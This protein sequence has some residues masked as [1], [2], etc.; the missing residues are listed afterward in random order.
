MHCSLPCPCS[1]TRVKR[2][3]ELQAVL[4]QIGVM[5]PPRTHLLQ[6]RLQIIL[7]L[8][9]FFCR[10]VCKSL[11]FHAFTCTR[12]TTSVRWRVLYSLRI[13]T[14]SCAYVRVRVYICRAAHASGSAG[15]RWECAC[16]IPASRDNHHGSCP[17]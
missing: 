4:M 11:T 8:I 12:K 2:R 13:C 5:L 15:L 7:Y 10:F 17:Q 1:C 6:V 3:K 16:A 9:R 14:L